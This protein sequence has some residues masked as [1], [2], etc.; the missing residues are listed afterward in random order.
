MKSYDKGHHYLENDKVLLRFVEAQITS[1]F[2]YK[3]IKHLVEHDILTGLANRTVYSD[4]LQHCIVH[5]S[6]DRKQNFSVLLIDLDEFKKINDGF[7]HGTGDLILKEVSRRLLKCVRDFDTVSRFGGDEFSI[8]LEQ[9]SGDYAVNIIA[10]RIVKTMAK[11]CI[12]KCVEFNLSVSLGIC[13]SLP[14]V[15]G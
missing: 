7:E 15:S 9:I 6:L 4:R 14:E 10:E 8:I 3:L 5:Y 1:F 2:K 13:N 11:P 12:L